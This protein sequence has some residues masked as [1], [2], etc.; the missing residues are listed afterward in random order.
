MPDPTDATATQLRN[1]EQA[2]GMSMAEFGSVIAGR[3]IESHTMMVAF[4]KAEYGLSHGNA[5]AVALRVRE[6]AAGGPAPASALLAAQYAGPRAALRPIGERLTAVAT[7]LGPDSAI[8]VQ[9]TGVALRRRKQ[10]GLIQVPSA[11]RVSLGLNLI[12]PSADPRLV[13]TPGAMC[14]YR[15]DLSDV[16]DVDEAVVAWLRTA[17]EQAG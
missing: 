3:G 1:V 13:A 9:K 6:M 5:N 4:L 14:A 16:A 12:D 10:F 2:T 7:G 8:L 17:Y 11:K 15:V